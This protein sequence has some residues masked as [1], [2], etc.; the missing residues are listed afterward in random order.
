MTRAKFLLT[1]ENWRSEILV[2]IRESE[3]KRMSL[4]LTTGW[5]EAMTR[6]L[7]GVDGE[8]WKGKDQ[9]NSSDEDL[10]RRK[11]MDPKV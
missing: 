11:F 4:P 6:V 2:C 7:S 3:G 10:K 1:K 9:L 5:S 8:K